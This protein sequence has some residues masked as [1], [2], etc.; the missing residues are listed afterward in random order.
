MK[1]IT[2]DI[3]KVNS[4]IDS[5]DMSTVDEVINVLLLESGMDDG[6]EDDRWNELTVLSGLL[7]R[8]FIRLSTKEKLHLIRVFSLRHDKEYIKYLE[9]R[10]K[11]KDIHQDIAYT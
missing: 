3:N 7:D 1:K 8:I 2:I 6:K 10:K 4:I 11:K 9:E 5:V